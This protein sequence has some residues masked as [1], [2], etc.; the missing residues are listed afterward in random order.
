MSAKTKDRERLL[1]YSN[2]QADFSKGKNKTKRIGRCELSQTEGHQFFSN[3][4]FL[5]IH[6]LLH[7][8]I[9]LYQQK[10]HSN[11]F[12]VNISQNKGILSIE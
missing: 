5:Y 4:L 1:D 9:I 8:S 6:H 12:I 11:Q 7:L 2:Q 3:F 10:S